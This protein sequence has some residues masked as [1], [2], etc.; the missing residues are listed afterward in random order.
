VAALTVAGA[1]PLGHGY[2]LEGDF[3]DA[4]LLEPAVGMALAARL[5]AV[6][7]QITELARVAVQIARAAPLRQTGAVCE[8]AEEALWAVAALVAADLR[9]AVA[10]KVADVAVG[11]GAVVAAE[12]GGGLD[13]AAE[14]L[15]VPAVLVGAAAPDQPRRLFAATRR[16]R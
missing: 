10:L 6:G 13:L 9:L 11:A 7:L 16:E 3:A 4:G 2:V 1:R 8:V 14:V 12:T 15:R 5:A